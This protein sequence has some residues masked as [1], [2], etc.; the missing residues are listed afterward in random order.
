MKRV[1]AILM[2]CMI[3]VSTTGCTTSQK[4]QGAKTAITHAA[5]TTQ[6]DS[7]K[8]YLADVKAKM[9]KEVKPEYFKSKEWKA[10]VDAYW[11]GYNKGQS[12]M[13]NPQY[14]PKEQIQY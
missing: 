6:L 9:A 7:A 14:M 13:K 1:I 4:K 5:K 12:Q 8:K 10:F 2:V 11:K 3:A